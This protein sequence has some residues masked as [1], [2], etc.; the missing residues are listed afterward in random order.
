M[1]LTPDDIFGDYDVCH[2][3][4]EKW[5]LLGTKWNAILLI[6]D[7]D[8]FMMKRL[9]TPINHNTKFS[10]NVTYTRDMLS[11]LIS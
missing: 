4:L 2:M 6:E 5:F 7:A 10:G 1:S 3:Q 11:S 8:V 9:E